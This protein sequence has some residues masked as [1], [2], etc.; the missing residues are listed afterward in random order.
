V[1][2]R[3]TPKQR[4]TANSIEC[5]KFVCEDTVVRWYYSVGHILLLPFC[6]IQG[7]LI[8]P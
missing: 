6:H 8:S 1:L 2:K 5:L 4:K 7:V 3:Q